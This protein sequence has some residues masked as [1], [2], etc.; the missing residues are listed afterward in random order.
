MPKVLTK[1]AQVQC[2]HGGGALLGGNAKLKVDGTPVLLESGVGTL[3]SPLCPNQSSSTTK[4]TNVTIAGGRSQKLF[5]DSNPV[6]LSTLSGSGDG[7]PPGTISA[8]EPQ[9]KLTAS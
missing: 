2:S 5:A 9:T 4:D 3:T 8:T 6:L 1:S 7:A